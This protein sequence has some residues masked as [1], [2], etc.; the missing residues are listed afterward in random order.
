MPRANAIT[1]EKESKILELRS[2]GK[3]YGEIA[4]ELNVSLTTLM[5]ILSPRAYE[6]RNLSRRRR[7]ASLIVITVSGKRKYLRVYGRRPKPS[8]CEF[9]GKWAKGRGLGWHHWNDD[10]PEWGIWLCW[11]CHRFAGSIERGK[12]E[13]YLKLKDKAIRGEL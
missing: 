2:H 13:R 7:R 1:P 5:R 3:S 12:H 8:E 11:S 4:S 6:K 9:C 10:H